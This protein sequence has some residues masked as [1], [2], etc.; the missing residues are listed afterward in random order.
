MCPRA[1]GGRLDRGKEMPWRLRRSR[2]A[3]PPTVRADG[4]RRFALTAL[5]VQQLLVE[6]QKRTGLLVMLSY[7]PKGVSAAGPPLRTAAAPTVTLES[8][9]TE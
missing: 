6:R 7:R 1:I 9:A 2:P 3:E 8:E 5:P 4:T